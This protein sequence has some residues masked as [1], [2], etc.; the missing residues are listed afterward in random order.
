MWYLFCTN[1]WLHS[2]NYSHKTLFD[3]ILQEKEEIL[4]VGRPAPRLEITKLGRSLCPPL[5]STSTLWPCRVC[6]HWGHSR[7]AEFR[8]SGPRGLCLGKSGVA[9]PQPAHLRASGSP[10]PAEA[11]LVGGLKCLGEKFILDSSRNGESIKV[12]SEVFQ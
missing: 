1:Y 5:P 8:G 2:C 11:C 9:P 3:P 7:E 12:V 6:F 10:E 4:R